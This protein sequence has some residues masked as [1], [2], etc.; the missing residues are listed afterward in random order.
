M[1][2]ESSYEPSEDEEN[3][4]TR[5]INRKYD[6]RSFLSPLPFELI[7]EITKY[8]LNLALTSRTMYK[9]GRSLLYETFTA[10]YYER[11]S[12][13]PISSPNMTIKHIKLIKRWLQN[14]TKNGDKRNLVK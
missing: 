10:P 6:Q 8:E 9:I 12:K 1:R 13:L 4:Y 5:N 3:I 7:Y 2:T 11:H 14:L